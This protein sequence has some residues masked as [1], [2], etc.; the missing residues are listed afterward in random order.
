MIAADEK[1]KFGPSGPF[2]CSAKLRFPIEVHSKLFWVE[3]V[4]VG[5]NIFKPLGAVIKIFSCGNGALILSD[6]EC[7]YVLKVA[8]LGKLCHSSEGTKV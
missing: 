3:V 6:V 1:F 2:G 8:H 5:N 7:H 4:I